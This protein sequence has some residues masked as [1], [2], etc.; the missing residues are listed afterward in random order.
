MPIHQLATR[1]SVLQQAIE[2]RRAVNQED[3][4]DLT[5]LFFQGNDE[6]TVTVVVTYIYTGTLNLRSIRKADNR[7]NSS[8][9]YDF[10]LICDAIVLAKKLDMNMLR[11]MLTHE[12][13]NEFCNNPISVAQLELAATIPTLDHFLIEWTF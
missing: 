4:V 2:S 7:P 11:S 6:D 8:S 10:K 5:H 9:E 1:S 12:R 3:M 13:F